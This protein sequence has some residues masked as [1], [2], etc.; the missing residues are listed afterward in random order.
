MASI[1]TA[2]LAVRNSRGPW[3]LCGRARAWALLAGSFSATAVIAAGGHH[4][5]DDAVILEPGNCQLESWLSRSDDRQRLL[6]AGAGCRVGPL[7]IGVA[8][9]NARQAGAS[10][11]GYGLQAKWATE[12][13]PGFNA[14]LSISGGWQARM[15]PRYQGS[16][17]SGLFSWFPRDDLALHLNLGRDFVH[18]DADLNRSGVSVEWTAR[19]GWSITAERYLEA[20]THFVRAGMRWAISEAWSVDLSRAHRLRGPGESNWTLGATWQFPRP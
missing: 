3:S 11:T 10:D 9:E 19:P 16:T 7:E 8:A 5:L 15:R 20:Q 4:A 12:L 2:G 13:V 17:L 6:H 1:P 14:G 18:R